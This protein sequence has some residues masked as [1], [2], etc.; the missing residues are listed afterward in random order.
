MANIVDSE[1][2]RTIRVKIAYRDRL[3]PEIIKFKEGEANC[4]CYHC[5]FSVRWVDGDEVLIP[6]DRILRIRVES[7]RN[8][9]E[10]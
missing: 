5:F 9:E 10:G 7:W 1:K 4:G 8:I 2:K 6:Y 3:A